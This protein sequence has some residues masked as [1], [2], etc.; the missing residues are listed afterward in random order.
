MSAARTGSAVALLPNGTVL[1]AGGQDSNGTSVSSAEI[2]DPSNGSFS[3]TGSMGTTRHYLAAT[4]LSNGLVLI[5]G[6]NSMVSGSGFALNTA[7]LYDPGRGTFAATGSMNYGRSLH[8]ATPLTNGLV[9]VTGG[10]SA[11][12]ELY[13]P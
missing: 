12:A 1:V 10:G 4:R 3:I 5:T 7:E 2:Y 13:T 6:G 11:T 9:L 8:L